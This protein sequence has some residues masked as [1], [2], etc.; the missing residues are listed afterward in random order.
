MWGLSGE[1]LINQFAREGGGQQ[2]IDNQN[3][4]QQN[5]ANQDI[6][7]QNKDQ[8][9]HKK[10]VPELSPEENKAVNQGWRSKE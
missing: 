2:K 3:T 5:I 8:L 6:D 4:D 10:N 1:Q 9:E 7:G